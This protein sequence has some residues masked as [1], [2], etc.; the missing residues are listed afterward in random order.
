MSWNETF[1][2]VGRTPTAL[3]LPGLGLYTAGRALT[4]LRTLEGKGII[5]ASGCR[6]IV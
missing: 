4:A 2:H 3:I 5:G 6:L 1:L